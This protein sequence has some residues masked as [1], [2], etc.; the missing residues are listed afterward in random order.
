MHDY[1]ISYEPFALILLNKAGI[2]HHT[3]H[4]A[5]SGNKSATYI[6]RLS[7]LQ[8]VLEGASLSKAHHD[9]FTHSNISSR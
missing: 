8:L 4:L 3:A 5:L 2:K 9:I 6:E 1:G 7:E